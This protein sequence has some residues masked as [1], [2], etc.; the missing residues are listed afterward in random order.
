MT[1]GI[2]G[3][4]SSYNFMDK[5]KF[6]TFCQKRIDGKIFRLEWGLSLI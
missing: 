3:Q 6:P 2:S 5:E 4:L 1:E